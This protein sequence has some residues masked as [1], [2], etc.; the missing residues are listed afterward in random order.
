MRLLS[1]ATNGSARYGAATEAGV[2]D[3]TSR[4]GD[5]FPDLRALIAG[6][7]LA[8]AREE[9]GRARPDHALEQLSLLPPI[10]APEKL[11][12]IGVNYTDRNAEYRD[13]SDLPKYPSLFARNPSSVVGSGQPLEKPR[14]S[15]QLDYEGELVIV[16]GQGGRHIQRDQAWS[17]IFGMTLCNEGTVRDWLRHGKFNVTQGKNFD[18]SGS[19]GPWIVTSDECDPHG[20]H[21]IVTRV[22]GEV[23]QQDSTERL[24]FPFDYLISYLSTFATLK[25]GDLIAT[26]T[27]TGAGARFDPPRWLKPGDVVE[28]ESSRIGTLRN[29]VV[30]EG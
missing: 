5:R 18:R 26:G 8:L 27:P 14:V 4:I 30:A 22:N 7:G 9:V 16:I 11:W 15:E 2:V 19:I 12:C 29:T 20:P 10:P 25:P 13:N 23:R 17:H 21:D 28:V 24:M 3:L 1:Y 6:N